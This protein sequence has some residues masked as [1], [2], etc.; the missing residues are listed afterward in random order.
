MIFTLNDFIYGCQICRVLHSLIYCSCNQ[1]IIDLEQRV[2]FASKFRLFTGWA[3]LIW[4]LWGW[5]NIIISTYFLFHIKNYRFN[6]KNIIIPLFWQIKEYYR[7]WLNKKVIP[8][9]HYKSTIFLY[10]KIPF[11]TTKYTCR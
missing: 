6:M 5:F 8:L 4:S 7:I 1:L 10:E 3:L 9:R 11:F 2:E